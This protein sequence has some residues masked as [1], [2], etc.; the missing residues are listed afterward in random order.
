MTQAQDEQNEM[1]IGTTQNNRTESPVRTAKTANLADEIPAHKDDDTTPALTPIESVENDED[2]EQTTTGERERKSPPTL[3][4][5]L[6]MRLT[7][8]LYQGWRSNAVEEKKD[9]IISRLP[10]FLRKHLLP[11]VD[12]KAFKN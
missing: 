4:P 5:L 2:V 6:E 9:L 11:G 10:T 8:T 12:Q 7:E 1:D 3:D